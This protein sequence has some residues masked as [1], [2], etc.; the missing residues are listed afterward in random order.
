MIQ[1]VDSALGRAALLELVRYGKSREMM[2]V[3]LQ[4]IARSRDSLAQAELEDFLNEMISRASAHP[5]LGQ[6]YYM[7][8]ELALA[9]NDIALAEAD[10]RLLL[11]QFPG[12][13]EIEN[14]YR[15]FAY[16]ALQRTPPQHRAAADFLIQLRDRGV[17][18]AER[19]ELNRL[20]GDCYFLKGDYADA[21][22]FYRAAYARGFE[23]DGEGL[24]LRLVT[25][26]LR[27]GQIESALVT[28]DQADF[29]GRIAL[30]DRWRVEW[31][32]AQALKAGGDSAQ[33]LQRVRL[34]LQTSADTAVPAVLD[35]RLRWLEARL[36]MLEGETEGLLESVDDLLARVRSFPEG[37]SMVRMP[38]C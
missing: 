11:E 23:G 24:L 2:S 27:S 7:R 38:A 4:L 18:E 35:L 31:N 22:D 19:T 32:L 8:S 30:M 6:M 33:A 5:L 15:L 17:V 9:R 10:A 20:I 3:A 34:L 12:L 36:R 28:V 21:V 25:A 13:Q 16:A 1:G 29:A 37:R 26:E 14:V